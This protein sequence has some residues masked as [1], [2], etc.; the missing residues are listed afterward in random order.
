M[1]GKIVNIDSD[2]ANIM[3]TFF[4]SITNFKITS[5]YHDSENIFSEGSQSSKNK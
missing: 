1:Y 2:T 3:N 5:E 4:S